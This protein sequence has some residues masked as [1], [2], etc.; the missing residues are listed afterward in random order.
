M[1]TAGDDGAAT[2]QSISPGSRCDPHYIGR[3]GTWRVRSAPIVGANVMVSIST[4]ILIM[5]TTALVVAGIVYAEW[6]H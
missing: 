6:G 4:I 3:H 1:C 5:L 2:A